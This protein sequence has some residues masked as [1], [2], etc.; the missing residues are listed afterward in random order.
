M[1]KVGLGVVGCGD[2]AFRTYF[3]AIATMG[4][5]ADLVAV[6]DTRAERGE[7]AR[8]QFGAARAYA[9]LDALLD[10]KA[11][12][13]VVNLT[14]VSSHASVGMKAL[15]AGKHLY[16]EKPIASALE[17]ADALI[18]EAEH[19]DLLIVCAPGVSLTPARQRV[20]DVVRSGELGRVGLARATGLTD[21]PA[22]WDDYS[23]DPS[24][25]YEDD[26][27]PLIDTGVYAVDYLVH[28]LGPARRVA[29]FVGL[30]R[31]EIT[32]TAR[33]AANKHVRAETPDSYSILL[34]FDGPSLAQLAASFSVPV[35]RGPAVEFLGDKGTV[36]VW[37]VWDTPQTEMMLAGE[38]SWTP[39][40]PPETA[41]VGV[42]RSY[43]MGLSHLVDCLLSETRPVLDGRRGRHVLEIMLAARESAATRKSID[44]RTSPEVTE[45]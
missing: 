37:E 13:V 19:R 1:A 41:S 43:T 6:C 3:P 40:D 20:A 10:D 18:G 35:A 31:P 7:K 21:G 2:V 36:A 45:G 5:K 30:V 23:S 29:A 16:Q 4:D 24:W 8:E 32:A 9:D 25:F 39:L 38:Q 22:R 26:V 15:Q 17:D 28:V 34:E 33:G 42:E 11:V 14:S 44:L 27:G 12:D